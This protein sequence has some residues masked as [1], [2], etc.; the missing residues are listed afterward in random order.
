MA[1]GW[2]E[3]FE[4]ETTPPELFEREEGWDEEEEFGTVPHPRILILERQEPFED[5]YDY[6]DHF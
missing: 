2:H 6:E 3:D 4:D 1:D 5:R